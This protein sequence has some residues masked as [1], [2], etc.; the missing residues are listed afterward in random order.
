[1]GNAHSVLGK[2]NYRGV[3]GVSVYREIDRDLV[4]IDSNEQNGHI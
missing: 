1:L 3:S 4:V 2:V